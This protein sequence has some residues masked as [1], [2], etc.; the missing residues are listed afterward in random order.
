MTNIF[1]ATN[2]ALATLSVPYAMDVFLAS[3]GSLPDTY[4]VYS[5]I[6]GVPVQSADNVE[7]M[8]GYRVQVSILSVN[9][10]AS[11]PDVDGAMLAAGF[12]KGPERA[13]PPD[14]ESRHFGLAKDYF[15]L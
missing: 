4:L 1:T 2:D 8:R 11:L 9:G 3:D 7:T 13:L 6:S 5:L 15:F 10:L 14:T 12:Q